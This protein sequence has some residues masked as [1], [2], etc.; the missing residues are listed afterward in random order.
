MDSCNFRFVSCTSHCNHWY[1]QLQCGG[2]TTARPAKLPS[3]PWNS[4]QIGSIFGSVNQHNQHTQ[5]LKLML[6]TFVLIS[7]NSVGHFK[8]Q[9]RAWVSS[10]ILTSWESRR[11]VVSDIVLSH[12]CHRATSVPSFRKECFKGSKYSSKGS[13]KMS[14]I[15]LAREQIGAI[16]HGYRMP[17]KCQWYAK[18]CYGYMMLHVNLYISSSIP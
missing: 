10:V 18:V 15:H 17:T 13:C 5:L 4:P 11:C 12:R 3:Q 8:T 16:M 6:C 14:A 7:E 2:C 1:S 9:G